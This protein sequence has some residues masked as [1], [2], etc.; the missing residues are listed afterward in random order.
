[1][2]ELID[3]S[4]A[5]VR[6]ALAAGCDFFAG[7]PITPASS[8]LTAMM[9]ELPKVGGV[10]IQGEDEISSIGM[11][12]G[13]AMAGSRA[14]TATSG[15]GLS[16]YS[17]NIGLAIMG[18]VPLVIVDVQRL[19]PA[20]GGATTTAQ[21]DVQFVRWGTSGGFP[22]FA[23]A[24]SSIQECAEL[25]SEAFRLA[26]R[27]RCPVFLMTDK[28]LNLTLNTVEMGDGNGTAG[29]SIP[30]TA[31][32][33]EPGRPYR[34]EPPDGMPP[35]VPYGGEA[36]VRFTGSS[37]D[38]RALITKDPLTVG[39]LNRHL[40]AK[41]EDHRAEIERV[42]ADLEPGAHT[43]FVSYGSTAR[44]MREAVR[45][46]RQAGRKVSAITVQSL[47]PVPETA[48]AAALGSGVERVVVAELNLGQYCREI[49]RLTDL[50]V[51]GLHRVDGELLTPEQFLET[52]EELA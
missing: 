43:L 51:F 49:E 30:G 52:L 16:L 28:E 2:R 4:T 25:T 35:L 11:C 50:P 33:A 34:Y 5:I 46:A 15:P 24:P 48:L 21:S 14:L 40:A 44:T 41:I 10:A 29:P 45:R 9:S 1:M 37:H 17:E 12:I 22:I 36:T 20:T 6:G 23:L 32:A 42:I 39:A 19:G 27:F 3:G 47:W 7:Y 31:G 26:Q 13:A 18:E 38:E 8:I